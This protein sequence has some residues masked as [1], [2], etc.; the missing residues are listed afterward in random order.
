MWCIETLAAACKACKSENQKQFTFQYTCGDFGHVKCLHEDCKY[1]AE[2]VGQ[3]E[4]H[5]SR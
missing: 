5:G 3:L 2:H 1:S 4:A